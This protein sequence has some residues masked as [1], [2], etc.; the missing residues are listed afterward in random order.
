MAC[1]N[2]V[3][4]CIRKGETFLKKFYWSDGSLVTKA[5]SAITQAAP[6]QITAA[7]HGLV[8][9]WKAAV[10]SARGMT[11]INA[12]NYPPTEQ[13]YH[14][15]AVVDS[16]NVRLTDVN[17]ADFS[18][19][20]SGGFLVY[21]APID[22]ASATAIMMIRDYP[23]SGVELLELTSSPAAGIVLDNTNK[24]IEVTFETAAVTWQIGYYDLEI[25]LSS[26]RIVQIADGAITIQ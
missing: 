6:V 11:E 20:T 14:D 15:V 24:V 25:T 12:N 18:A 17:S 16:N 22:L 21:P 13:E 19:Y 1:K 9:G 3:D 8:N 7:S 2:K 26:G 23:E 5:I 10:V 4:F